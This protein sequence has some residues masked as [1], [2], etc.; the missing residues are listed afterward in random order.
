MSFINMLDS[1]NSAQDAQLIAGDYEPDRYFPTDINGDE[2][3]ANENYWKFRYG[4]SDEYIV[5]DPDA[6]ADYLTD[7]SYE[8][9]ECSSQTL[10]DDYHA[11]LV[12]F[13]GCAME[14]EA[15]RSR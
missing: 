15:R 8:S 9:N 11:I 7:E 5:D 10:Q 6:I 1:L 12:C 3:E 14:H 2:V 4:Y 13:D